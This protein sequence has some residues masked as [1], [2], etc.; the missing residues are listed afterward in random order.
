M[1]CYLAS[2]LTS[3]L[4]ISTSQSR[5]ITVQL[6]ITGGENLLKPVR[7]QE[8]QYIYNIYTESPPPPGDAEFLQRVREVMIEFSMSLPKSIEEAVTFYVDL[9]TILENT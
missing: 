8:V 7:M 3:K 4:S 5:I 9:W 6:I 2:L 1:V